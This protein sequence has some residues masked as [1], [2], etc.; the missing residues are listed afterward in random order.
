MKGGEKVYGIVWR[1]GMIGEKLEDDS[2]NWIMY[3]VL[4]GIGGDG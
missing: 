2:R 3:G 1:W 4:G